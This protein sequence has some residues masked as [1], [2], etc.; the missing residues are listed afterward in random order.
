MGIID[1]E[2]QQINTAIYGQEMRT[3]IHDGLDKLEKYS[4]ETSLSANA[5]RALLN[6]L[7][8]VVY[9]DDQG[10]SYYE[11]LALTLNGDE[12]TS[13]TAVYSPGTFRP[14]AGESL[15]VLRPYLTV[16]ANYS[17]GNTET[18]QNYTLDGTMAAGSQTITVG[19]MGKTTTVTVTVYARS[20][21]ANFDFTT[22]MTD[23]AGHYTPELSAGDG[24]QAPTRDSDGLKFTQ[25]TQQ[26][27]IGEI[28][29]VGKTFEF[30]VADF[31][32]KGNTDYHM[33]LFLCC[34]KKTTPDMFGMSPFVFRSNTGYSG[35]AW[36]NG[37]ADLGRS[38]SAQPWS[39]LQGEN[40]RSIINGKTVKL[41]FEN[42]HTV[43]LYIDG[44]SY[45]KQTDI[46]YNDQGVVTNIP[47]NCKHISFGSNGSGES[48]GDQCY[49]LTLSGFRVYA[50]E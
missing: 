4:S 9:V 17:S 5:K 39:G 16:T 10:Q 45:G 43:A 11:A 46:Y 32:F 41:V 8:H 48:S 15:D 35:Y 7:Q 38:W 30:D 24:Y 50:N 21:L 34:N 20:Y 42:S 3:A 29:P 2:L 1:N 37:L 31:D 12:V 25:P 28:D 44:Q 23:L 26:L 40:A 18:V 14:H 19:Y 13:L 49:D 27:Y 36:A 33:R 22:S 47:R 6:L